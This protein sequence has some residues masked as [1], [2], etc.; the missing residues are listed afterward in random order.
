MNRITRSFNSHGRTKNITQT[1]LAMAVAVA[2][3]LPAQGMAAQVELPRID[4]ISGGEEAI[5][6]QPGSV[7]IVNQEQL[8]RI[9]PLSTEDALRKVPGV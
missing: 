4:V 8:E 9:Q 3:N 5:A 7:S 1:K 6:K 2:L